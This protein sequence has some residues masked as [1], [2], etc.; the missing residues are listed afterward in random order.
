MY[1]TNLDNIFKNTRHGL[2]STSKGRTIAND[3]RQKHTEGDKILSSTSVVSGFVV[4][5]GVMYVT[6]IIV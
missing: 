4:G 6:G 3:I 1:R 2:K 5:M